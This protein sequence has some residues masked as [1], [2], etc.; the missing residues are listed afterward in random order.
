MNCYGFRNQV[1]LLKMT[2][3]Q[4]RELQAGKSGK[5]GKYRNRPAC[6]LTPSGR[7]IRFASQKEARRYDEL[8]LLLRSG[9]ISGLKVHPQYTLLDAYTTADGER[10][11]AVRYEADFEYRDLRGEAVVEDCKGGKATKTR[12]YILKKKLMLEKHGIGVIEI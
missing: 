9:E 11:A 2:V 7:E 8:M 1:I 4:L 12:L 3:E 5:P 6:R 10:S